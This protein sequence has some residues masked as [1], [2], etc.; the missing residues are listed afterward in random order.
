MSNDSKLWCPEIYQG[1][2][3]ERYND[4]QVRY[5][6]CCNSTRRLIDVDKFDFETD[7]WL[8][9]LRS[10]FDQN[11][12]PKECHRCWNKEN[13]GQPSRRTDMIQFYHDQ[14]ID[15][16]SKKISSLDYYS[17]WACNLACVMCSPYYS[18]TWAQELSLN[19]TQKLEI[20]RL[21]HRRNSIIDR[22][23][24]SEVRKVHFNGGEPLLNDDH[25]EVLEKI[26][27]QGRL[28][29]LSISYNTN[30]TH[31]PS[32]KMIDLWAE[33]KT[34]RI[35]FSIDGI[36]DAFEY[37]RWPARW[38][39]VQDNILHMK[40]TLPDN[41]SFG[42]NTAVGINLFDLPAVAKWFDKHLSINRHG[43]PSNFAW[44]PMTINNV[45][46]IKSLP[47]AV[48]SIAIEQLKSFE[49][50]KDIVSYIELSKDIENS[51][52]WTEYLDSIDIKRKLYWRDQLA[53]GNYF[54]KE[55][56]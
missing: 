41:V 24:L 2:N 16:K 15:P 28:D 31:F 38:H 52:G 37:I 27:N 1:L 43:D 10:Q 49:M 48:K 47:R 34:V 32:K 14:N 33:I 13:A 50:L 30:G 7:A 23:D 36:D 51:T 55:E 8:Q 22:L 3:I 6:P 4:D 5:S 40:E 26:S 19:H 12:Q 18:S 56:N 20:G 44:Q 25:L 29:T 54:C 53:I 39:Q 11:Q 35:Y 17:S 21:Y 46:V 42:F 45:D 9:D